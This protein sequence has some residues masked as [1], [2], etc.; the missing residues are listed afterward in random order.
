MCTVAL[1]KD[2]L[3]LLNYI[4]THFFG[5][6]SII[7]FEIKQF[8]IGKYRHCSVSALC[9]IGLSR[10]SSYIYANQ[11]PPEQKE[12]KT[13]LNFSARTGLFKL[14]SRQFLVLVFKNYI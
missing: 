14:Q 13:S 3:K 5:Y 6:N 12:I 9:W 8:A 11:A 7:N 10:K 4:S 2:I 1:V